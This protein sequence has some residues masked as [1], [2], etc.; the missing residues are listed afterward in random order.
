LCAAGGRPGWLALRLFWPAVAWATLAFSSLFCLMGAYFRRSAVVAL[1]YFG[2]LEVLVGNLPGYLKRIS[3]G[4]FARCMMFEAAQDYG[5]QP[6]KPSVYLPVEAA[7]AQA[8]L[9][10]MTAGFLLLGMVVFTR[11]QYHEVV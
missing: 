11:T 1:L 10:G 5:L 8:V 7:T 6:Q 3:I 2:F 9:L 4:F